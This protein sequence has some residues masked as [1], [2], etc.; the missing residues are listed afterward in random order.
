MNRKAT[1]FILCVGAIIVLGSFIMQV[2]EYNKEP[3]YLEEEQ[4]NHVYY[5]CDLTK[6]DSA[7]MSINVTFDIYLRMAGYTSLPEIVFQKKID[8]KLDIHSELSSASLYMSREA[9]DAGLTP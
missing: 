7:F 5:Q 9:F 3:H 6:R 1:I 8:G 2:I 4:S